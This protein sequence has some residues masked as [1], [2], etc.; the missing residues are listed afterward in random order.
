MK[1]MIGAVLLLAIMASGCVTMT[2]AYRKELSEQRM[3]AKVTYQQA[4]STIAKSVAEPDANIAKMQLEDI[5]NQLL[6]IVQE[7]YVL[8]RE[9]ED[10][11]NLKTVPSDPAKRQ[12]YIDAIKAELD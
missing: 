4:R 6:M 3:L 7:G 1:K 11:M 12:A 5:A 9:W 8:R 2:P 10:A